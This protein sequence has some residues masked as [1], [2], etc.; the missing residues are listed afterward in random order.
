P[1]ARSPPP[2]SATVR[3]GPQFS[4]SQSLTSATTS[5]PAV[6]SA[7]SVMNTRPP[8]LDRRVKSGRWPPSQ[9]RIPGQERVQPRRGGPVE[10]VVGA[11]PGR[12]VVPPPQQPRSVAEPPALEVL[13]AHLD[14][15]LGPQR[16]PRQVL[17]RVPPACRALPRG[18]GGGAGGRGPGGAAPPAPP[19]H[20]WPSSAPSRSG[21]TSSTSSR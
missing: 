14:R 1:A 8:R 18:G 19:R 17:G 10:L 13:V 11:V 5:V 9:A 6:R 7:V 20:G 12:L 21:A 16:L 4:A 15:P 2:H 3:W